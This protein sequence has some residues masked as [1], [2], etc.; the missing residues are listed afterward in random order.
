M[1]DTHDERG[2]DENAALAVA[3]YADR[4]AAYADGRSDADPGQMPVEAMWRVRQQLRDL[5]EQLA[6][7][8]A[9]AQTAHDQVAE[10][11]AAVVELR[12]ER[13]AATARAEANAVVHDRW[14]AMRI[15]RDKATA[16]AEKAEAL[17]REL[18]RS[19][20]RHMEKLGTERDAAV[21]RAQETEARLA[22]FG[23]PET[24]QR[25]I[26]VSGL[27]STP[28]RFDLEHRADWLPGVRLEERQVYPT[29]WR[30]AAD[31]A[32]D[33]PSATEAGG[34]DAP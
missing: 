11:G 2:G 18:A 9:H 23:K 3:Q 15:E 6:A 27:A 17:N 7:A 25:I 34:E 31:T 28:T 33:G 12:A 22:E 5:R 26:G 16:R 20:L 8:T 29:P 4:Y 19:N 10:L 32:Q 1:P 30:L 24:E 13:D 14:K 21:K